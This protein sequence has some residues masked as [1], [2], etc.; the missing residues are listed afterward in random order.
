MLKAKSVPEGKLL[1]AKVCRNSVNLQ[2]KYEFSPQNSIKKWLRCICLVLVSWVCPGDSRQYAGA[3]V[4]TGIFYPVGWTQALF[5]HVAQHINIA[6]FSPFWKLLHLAMWQP[7][8]L[9][10]RQKTSSDCELESPQ[11]GCFCIDAS[12]PRIINRR[13]KSCSWN[14]PHT[15]YAVCVYVSEPS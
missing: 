9:V 5:W 13:W 1:P 6:V 4:A 11:V 8:K 3:K 14:T 10:W 15:Y 2:G 7:Q 12:L